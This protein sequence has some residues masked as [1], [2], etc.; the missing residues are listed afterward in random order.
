[1]SGPGPV[2]VDYK[3]LSG[4]RRLLILLLAVVT[5]VA[6][7][8]TLLD[9]PGGVRRQHLQRVDAPRCGASQADGECVGGKIEVIVP[10]APVS[11]A[12]AAS[13]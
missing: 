10:A 8:T 7:V 4:R 13:R 9:P 5:A 1:M 12:P 2:H 11:P 6:V 3:S